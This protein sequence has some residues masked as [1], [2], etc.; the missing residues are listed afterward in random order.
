M[1]FNSLG[2]KNISALHKSIRLDRQFYKDKRIK[3]F[4]RVLQLL[5]HILHSSESKKIF[6]RFASLASPV[7]MSV[8]H[9]AYFTMF[10]H[11][12]KVVG[13]VYGMRKEKLWKLNWYAFLLQGFTWLLPQKK[14]LPSSWH[15]YTSLTRISLGSLC[16]KLISQSDFRWMSDEL[17][18]YVVG[19]FEFFRVE[20]T[21]QADANICI[22]LTSANCIFLYKFAKERMKNI[23][24]INNC[25]SNSGVRVLLLNSCRKEALK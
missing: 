22:T 13:L 25:S 10:Q 18:H 6:T 20:N 8:K 5:G 21:M 1:A 14:Y 19:S 16:K 3:W 24:D 2:A 23:S 9:W 17:S 7:S 11:F 15:I 4:Y 12:V